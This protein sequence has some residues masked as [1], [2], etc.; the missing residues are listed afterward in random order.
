M[1]LKRVFLTCLAAITLVGCAG[2]GAQDVSKGGKLAVYVRQAEEGYSDYKGQSVHFAYSADGK[3]YTPI[4]HNYGL[5]FAKCSYSDENGIRSKGVV[6]PRIYKSGSK[7]IIAADEVARI[8]I[9]EE[10]VTERTDKFVIWETSDFISFSEAEVVNK[11]SYGEPISVPCVTELHGAVNEVEIDV[12]GDI[13]KA[14][15]DYY[16]PLEFVSVDY[17]KTFEITSEADLDKLYATVTYSDGSTHE[18]RIVLDTSKIDFSRAGKYKVE[19]KISALKMPFPL[20]ERPWGDPVLTEWEGKYY[21]LGTNDWETNNFEIRSAD[22]IEGLF[23]GNEQR[24]KILT[25]EGKKFS[26]F[27]APEFHVINGKMYIFCALT[28]GEGWNPQAHVM[29]LKEGGDMLNPDD[30]YEPRACVFPDGRVLG[31]DPL[32]T[33]KS[34]IG[35]DMNYFEANGKGYVSWSYRT[36]WGEDSGSMILLAETDLDKPWQLLSEPILLTRP[37]Y[38]WENVD[39]T[40]NNEGPNTVVRDGKVYIVY[41]AGNA[42]GDSYAL[43]MLTAD[44]NAD[45][46]DIN[47]WEKSKYPV[48]ASDFVEGEIGCGHHSFYF[49]GDG[50]TYILYHGHKTFGNSERI[51]GM[52][53]VQYLADGRP[54]V[55]LSNEQDIP[56]SEQNVRITVVVK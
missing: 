15:K 24:A 9:G 4:Y 7:Y 25:D 41:S 2:C 19:G 1:K 11:L 44:E 17:P 31:T 38:G 53:R 51:D 28:P 33:G 52:R 50:N 32:G 20:E 18:K 55:A 6:N 37:E 22:T 40:D 13:L 36:F 14:V 23:N 3:T 47:S 8:F 48:L 26:T 16:A 35:I 45:L 30:W 56:E 39:K 5:L 54:Y 49:G 29:E 46:L 12:S 21:F 42:G 10:L 34:G 43:G 27:W